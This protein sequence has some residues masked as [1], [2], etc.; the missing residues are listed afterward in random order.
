MVPFCAW[1]LYR[2]DQPSRPVATFSGEMTK[3][4]NQR[5][6]AIC[7][8]ATAE[9]ACLKA[10]IAAGGKVRVGFENSMYMADGSIAADNAARVR[11]A[12]QMMAAS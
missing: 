7:A 8:F 4:R 3:C 9:A 6:L 1:S 10:A 2:P 12:K 5:R 11:E